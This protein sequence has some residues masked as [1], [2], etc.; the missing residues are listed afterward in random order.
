MTAYLPFQTPEGEPLFQLD[1]ITCHTFL[2]NGIF[3][4]EMRQTETEGQTLACG[5]L[6][7]GRKAFHLMWKQDEAW[8]LCNSDYSYAELHAN[9]VRCRK[10]AT[11]TALMLLYALSTAT[12][13]TLL[14]HA[15]TIVY[16]GHAYLFLGISGTGKST[17]SKLWMAHIGN[18][19][20]LNDDNPVVRMAPDGTFL[21]YGTPW[22][23]KTPCYR[24]ECHP[25]GA[26]VKLRQCQENRI[27]RMSPVATYAAIAAS[28]SGKRWEKSIGNGLHTTTERMTASTDGWLLN[29]LPDADAAR[30]CQTHIT[31]R[32]KVRPTTIK[33]Q[34]ETYGNKKKSSGHS[35]DGRGETSD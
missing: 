20:L 4:E 30:L 9:N 3:A 34:E 18:C 1:I 29:C 12:R 24:N 10:A 6:K 13:D 19:R 28:V 7:D 22:S 11:D 27:Y 32:W 33:H 2:P 5:I 23:G 35:A 16:E 8:L 31:A 26:I 15:S 14:F 17:H 25:L 21:V